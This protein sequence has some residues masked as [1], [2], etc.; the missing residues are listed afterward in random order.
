MLPIPLP[1]KSGALDR[2][3]NFASA[4]VQPRHVDVWLPPGYADN[5]RRRY[6]VLYAHDGQ[7]LFQAETAYG[8]VT[9]GVAETMTRLIQTGAIQPAIVVG[10]W[11][12]PHRWREYMPQRAF[13]IGDGAGRL[14]RFTELA[15]G[16]PASDGY[17]RFLTSELKPMID[18][19]YRTLPTADHT[20]IMGSSMGGLISAYALCEYPTV[21][22]GA[23]CLSTHWVAGDGIG[24]D[25]L[26]LYL[27]AP[28]RHRFYFDHGSLGED[29]G[30]A[31]YQHRVD[32][33]MAA[34]G[35][36]PGH[37]WLT[38]VFPGADHNEAAWR[39][40]LHIPLTFLLGTV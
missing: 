12:T 28:G 17:L 14:P 2:Y 15:G 25:Y 39:T 16:P 19:T 3:P 26:A 30:Y 7:N 11:N 4:Y 27:P 38:Q 6:P 13:E 1:G 21:F 5:P 34:A 37:D 29:A 40:R 10:C 20:F 33:R 8:G 23:A 32:D 35:Y 31:P 24:V 9:W 36:I 18:V 22:S